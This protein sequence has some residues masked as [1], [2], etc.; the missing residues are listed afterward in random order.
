LRNNWK[1]ALGIVVSALLLWWVF[2]GEDLGAIARG[3]AAADPFLLALSGAITTTGGLIRAAQWRLLLDPLGVKTSFH[4]R[5]AS[6]N[7]GFMVTNVFPA[8]LGEIVRPF[9]LS[10]MTSAP[11]SG[12]LG[13]VVLARLLDVVALLILLLVTLAAP[14]FPAGSTIFGRSITYAVS[15]AMLAGT[16]ALMILAGALV[17][18]SIVT[19]SAHVLARVLPSH[20]EEAVVAGV[21]SFLAGLDVLRRPRALARALLWSLF[22]WVWMAGSFLAAFR[23][24]G[25][26]LGVTA[27]MFTQCA[28]SIFVALPAGPGFIGTM[29]AGVSVAV[30]EIFGAPIGPTLS[31]AVGYHLAGFIPVTL[32]GFYYAWRLGLDL[33]TIKTD[34]EAA[35]EAEPSDD[36]VA[37]R[38]P[39]HRP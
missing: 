24:F 36:A 38:G 23:A 12:V 2:R 15:G 9:A 28:V 30:H 8:R 18:P 35:V 14:D 27:A 6:L 25:I 19:R 17:W 16:A 3:L 7:I 10:R 21:E 1:A 11:V 33:G 20:L 22:L 29:Q 4:A 31:L 37:N 32:L 13:T 39:F 34:A 26:E 5:W